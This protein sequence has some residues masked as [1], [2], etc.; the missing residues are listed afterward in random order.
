[1]PSPTPSRWR[2]GRDHQ[3]IEPVHLLVA[4]LDQQG[5]SL[6][7]LFA[8][9]GVNVAKLRGELGSLL[10]RIPRVEGTPG[11]V[12]VSPDLQRTLNV[13]DKLAQA[14][15]DQYI[16]SEIFA[17]AA[18]EDRGELGRVAE[19]PWADESKTGKIHR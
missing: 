2:W 3:Q 1:M 12:H 9:A 11:E 19:E 4:L 5:G 7:P 8:K 17:L 14:R 15:G 6:K 16:A 13:T 10:D 18:L